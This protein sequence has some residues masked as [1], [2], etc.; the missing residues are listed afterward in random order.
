MRTTAKSIGRFVQS[1]LAVWILLTV[2]SPDRAAAQAGTALHL[3]GVDDYVEVAHDAALN[4]FPLTITAWVKTLHNTNL[5]EGIVKKYASGL[6]NGYSLHLYNGRLY[7]WY[8]RNGANRIYTADPGLDGGA[9]ADGHWHHVAFVVGPSGGSLY[10]DGNL[11]ISQAWT[12]IAGATTSSDSLLIGKYSLSSAPFTNSFLGEIDE[13]T[14]WNRALN[15]SEVNY[16]KH[17]RLNGNE[18][19]LLGLWHFDEGGGSVAANSVSPSL[20]GAVANGPAWVPS[21]AAVALEPVAA[22]CLKLDGV[23]GY[24]RVPHNADLNAY[25]FTATGWFRTTNAASS[26]QGIVSKYV[27]GSGNGWSLFVQNGRLRGFYY[28]TFANVAMD[29]T[30]VALVSDGGW[31]HAAMT[32]DATGARLARAGR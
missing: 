16:L 29:A 14:L 2:A 11:R 32:V 23:N 18:D 28:R 19:G 15:A 8:F 24:A 13:A 27:D 7:G 10:V 5:Y 21:H 3:D 4:T 17:R 25:P 9:I 31:H 20:V 1:L 12:G 22:S 6:A 26:V 30:S